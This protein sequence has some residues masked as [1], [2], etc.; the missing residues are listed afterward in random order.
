MTPNDPTATLSGKERGQR[1]RRAMGIVRARWPIPLILL[2]L[3]LPAAAR[4]GGRHAATTP[5]G[6]VGGKLEYCQ[7]CHGMSG[8][9]YYGY[10]PIPRLAGQQPEYLKNQLQAF[11]ERRRTSNIMFNVAHSLSPGMLA[12]LA[13]RFSEFNPPPLGGRREDRQRLV[14][15]FLRTGFPR[16]ILP[17][18]RR[19]MGRTD[20]AKTKSLGWQDSSTHTS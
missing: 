8:Q 15:K 9:G 3:A 18:A 13:E 20:E 6:E 19:A 4:V 17:L 11:N 12:A 10:Y 1:R 16:R 2:V 14:E 7:D 5:R